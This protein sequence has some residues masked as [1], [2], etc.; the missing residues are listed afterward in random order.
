MPRDAACAV[1]ETGQEPV[2]RAAPRSTGRAAD[3][4][5]ALTDARPGDDPIRWVNPAFELLTG[6]PAA[7][8]L[9]SSC[10]ILQG[11]GT[12]ESTIA[13]LT[14]ALALHETA[15]ETLLIRRRDGTAVWV[16]L[17]VS[18]VRDE[19]GAVIQ[20]LVT[21]A[22]VSARTRAQ[23]ARDRALGAQLQARDAALGRARRDQE[24]LG[25]LARVSDE[26]TRR[27]DL[28]EAAAA[29]AEVAVPALATWGYVV[30]SDDGHR[31]RSVRVA[32]RDPAMAPLADRLQRQDTTWLTGS[33]VVS[34]GLAGHLDQV[35]GPFPV[36]VAGLPVRTTPEQLE[37]LGALGLGSALV[38]PL[39]A[40]D[41]VIGLLVLVQSDP[42]GF[43]SDVRLTAAHLSHRAGLALDNLRL[44][45]GERATALTLQRSLLPEIP[46]V[47]GLDI[48]AR[49]LPVQHRAAVGGDWF[50]VLALPDGTVGLAVGDVMGHDVRAAASMGQL[51]SVL[52]SYAWDGAPTGRVVDHLDDLVRGLGMADVATCTYLRLER[53][54]AG[55][56]SGIMTYTSAGHPPPLLRLPDGT[57]AV[58]SD[59]LS[60]PIGVPD[61]SGSAPQGVVQVPR[62]SVLVVYSDGLV[63]RRDR[64][65]R[66]GID[67]L[68]AALAALPPSSASSLCDE[69]LA[70]CVTA[71]QED[72]VCLLVVGVR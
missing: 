22:D 39:R 13:R 41:G 62:G 1:P 3:L 61:P 23:H 26:L 5:M 8:L 60:T 33:P 52:R 15:A 64:S 17:L 59:G 54:A 12:D 50:D 19:Q 35:T 57:V 53:P 14:Q 32:V 38:V 66:D 4:A 51:R 6:Y 63:E 10:R 71:S 44:Y 29:L 49:Y 43:S 30:L 40:R 11:P 16:Q 20:H 70:R 9:G 47:D 58:L 18:A 2:V 42:D 48:D 67:S 65:L 55:A 68:V 46:T 72:D 31:V 28:D 24:R 56:G 69:L 7:E 21:A 27:L 25:L 37:L 34:A 36:D 45:L